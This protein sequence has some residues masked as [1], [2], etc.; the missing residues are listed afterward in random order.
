MT[1]ATQREI[2]QPSIPLSKVAASCRA[3]AEKLRRALRQILVLHSNPNVSRADR[4]RIGLA[5]YEREFGAKIS[6]RYL[7]ELLKRAIDRDAGAENW[8]RLEIYLPERLIARQAPTLIVSQAVAEL[9]GDIGDFVSA[10]ANPHSLT[11]TE[12]TA[13]WALAFKSYRAALE[14]GT[15]AKRAARQVREILLDKAPFLAASRDALLKAFNRK[16]EKLEESGGEF[17]ALRDGRALNG[18]RAEVPE[19]DLDRLRASAAFKNGARIDA[20]WREE[21]ARLSEQTRKRY[22]FSPEAPRKI[23]ELLVRQKVDAL[24]ARHQGKR[25][26]RRMVGGVERDW[27]G[28]PSMREWV[29]DDMTS[30]IEVAYVR[31]DGST[32]LL[33][34]QIVAVMDSASRKFVGWSISNDKGPTAE[35]CCSAILEGFKIHGV[36]PVLGVEN[37]FVFGK[38]LNI[39]GKEDEQGRMI[40]AGLAQYGCTVRHFDRMNPTSKAELEK[41]FDLIQQRME[42]HPGYTGRMQMI[43]APEDFKQEGRLIRSGKVDATDYRYTLAEFCE[44]VMEKIFADYNN[45]PQRGHLNGLSPNEAHEALKDK[46]N[47]PIQYAPELEWLL[48]PRY[49]V[50]VKVGG[51][52]FMHYGRSIRVRGGRL[53][54]LVGTELWAVMDR[55]DDSLVTFMNLNFTETFTL[56]VCGKPSASERTI[57][58]GSGVLGRE[59][60]K[61]REHERA[62][63]EERQDLLQRYGN[64][65][66]DLLRAIRNAPEVLIDGAPGSR[67]IRI[68]GNHLASGMEMQQQRAEIK[69][70]ISKKA[71]RVRNLRGKAERN[72]VPAILVNDGDEDAA[73]ALE[74]IDWAKKQHA[75]EQPKTYVLNPHKS[76]TKKPKGNAP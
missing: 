3:N 32:E 34:P 76:Y 60:A 20:A 42:R 22:P 51:V 39:N 66:R 1:G 68:S 75:S 37:G 54:E 56:E 19:E 52:R 31:R 6:D 13:V 16:L 41:A 9:F 25:V 24:W 72:G 28:I 67:P 8:D 4:E 65:R 26:L 36:P 18:D 61:I 44:K 45:T 21:Y 62:I 12:K 55:T 35:L 15:P 40:V 73:E 71:A 7:R 43:D 49:P 58:P 27:T 63:E 57:A 46:T 69:K 5:D 23:H 33:L 64:P 53:A 17:I 11:D 14:S 47:P 74:M 10:C 2:W 70:D 30:N 50:T 59:R 29:V 38:S 48:N